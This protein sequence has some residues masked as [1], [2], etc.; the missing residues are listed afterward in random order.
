[1]NAYSCHPRP[2]KKILSGVIAAGGNARNKSANGASARPN[3]VKRVDSTA[4]NSPRMIAAIRPASARPNVSASAPVISP[5]RID[6][7]A[8]STTSNGVGKYAR[9]ARPAV[10]TACQS[11]TKPPTA[12]T[13][14]TPLRTCAPPN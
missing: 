6:T 13:D 11:S 4:T 14:R 2:K 12:S 9:G 10:A 8:A 5:R 1:M 3:N 7:P